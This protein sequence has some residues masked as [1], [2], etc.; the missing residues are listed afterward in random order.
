MAAATTTTRRGRGPTPRSGSPLGR[1]ER[2]MVEEDEIDL[3]PYF[4]TLL[5]RWR[6]ILGLTLA[7]ALLGAAVTLAT[8]ATY[9]AT[10]TVAIASFGSKPVPDAK[11][12]LEL[13]TSDRVL[14][15][16]AGALA[17]GD[18]GVAPDPDELRASMKATA[19]ADPSLLKLT[20]R[21]GDPGRA[22]LM[23][24]AWSAAFV[25]AANATFNQSRDTLR[26]L[27][28]QLDVA[29][30]ELGRAEA[31][32]AA[33]SREARPELLRSELA[34]RQGLLGKVYEDRLRLRSASR[35]LSGLL[36]R[37]RAADDGQ[38]ADPADEVGLLLIQAKLAGTPVQVQLPDSPRSQRTV[39]ALAASAE[40]LATEVEERT[41]S[42]EG[43]IESLQRE[44]AELQQ[45][46][47]AAEGEQAP[48]LARRDGARQV[49][50]DLEA[51]AAQ[52]RAAASAGAGQARVVAEAIPPAEALPRG[53]ARNAALAGILG[54]ML[55]VA[56]TLGVEYTGARRGA[57][58]LG[59]APARR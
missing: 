30:A 36:E 13:A 48:L 42:A 44:I 57:M 25:E 5:R 18:P 16:V 24:S 35:E 59:T 22:D 10:A 12:Y 40:R 50:R 21:D 27:E 46:I 28:P 31:E 38:S 45:R 39:G 2:S 49:V 19:G 23:A 7:A 43:E 34:A 54:L 9:E 11:G 14:A 55:G 4:E 56:A 8:P 15:E 32:L 17:K 33:W 47:E 26:Q 51:K 1:S 6:L 58:A 41:R 20:A 37:L 53:A 52:A 29:R 3:R